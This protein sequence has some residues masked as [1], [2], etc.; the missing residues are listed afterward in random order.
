MLLSDRD[1]RAEVVAG[2]MTLSNVVRGPFL[3]ASLGYWVGQDHR[4]RGVATAAVGQVLRLAFA[5][6]G[7][8]R[9]EASTLLDNAASRRVLT[10]WR[11]S[12]PPPVISTTW[13]ALG[14]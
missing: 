9:V 4:G 2:R 8:H 7:L 6:L 13:R 10:V 12:F 14:R 5:D 1:I 3:S 11:A